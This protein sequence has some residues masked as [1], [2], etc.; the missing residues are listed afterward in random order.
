MGIP[1]DPFDDALRMFWL[2]SVLSAKYLLRQQLWTALSLV[3]SRLALFLK[4][5]RLAYDPSRADWGWSPVH[6]DLPRPVLEELAETVTPLERS[7]F[8]QAH[9]SDG[10]RRIKTNTQQA[11]RDGYHQERPLRS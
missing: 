11:S 8:D 4:L 7:S 3:E 5:W 9:P 2:G 6:T 10:H 1:V